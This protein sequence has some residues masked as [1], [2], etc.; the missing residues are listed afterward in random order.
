MNGQSDC[1]T[2]SSDCKGL[3]SCESHGFK[4]MTQA[5]CTQ[6]KSEMKKKG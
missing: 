2:A 1:K 6:A 4:E 3:N 5:A